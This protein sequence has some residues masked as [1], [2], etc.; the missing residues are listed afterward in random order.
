MLL[1]MFPTGHG[2]FV[3]YAEYCSTERSRPGPSGLCV[4]IQKERDS[5]GSHAEFQGHS[6]QE[7]LQ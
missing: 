3:D 1:G 2:L 5:P 6:E 4:H 7:Q